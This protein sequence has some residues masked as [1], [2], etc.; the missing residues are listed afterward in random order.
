[1]AT[2]DITK[3][4]FL[5]KPHK[6]CMQCSRGE[7]G[8]CWM[9]RIAAAAVAAATTAV[10]A[11]VNLMAAARAQAVNPRPQ[12]ARMQQQT[13]PVSRKK[14]AKRAMAIM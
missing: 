2:T 9:A 8:S 4:A 1:M 6:Q 10:P 5:G 14:A 7:T 13:A 3:L 11:I 12:V